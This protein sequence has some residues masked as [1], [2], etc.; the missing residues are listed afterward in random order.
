MPRRFENPFPR[1]KVSAGGRGRTRYTCGKFKWR[2]KKSPAAGRAGCGGG[3]LLGR[4]NSIFRVSADGKGGRDSSR[5]SPLLPLV[6]PTQV[7][8]GCRRAQKPE[9]SENMFGLAPVLSLSRSPSAKG[10]TGWVHATTDHVAGRRRAF[11]A[12]LRVCMCGGS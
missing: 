9:K 8:A 5:P 6:R 11:A 1:Q 7:A 10:R 4:T 2:R 12:R 3:C